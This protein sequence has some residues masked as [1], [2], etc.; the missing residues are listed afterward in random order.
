MF[1]VVVE[2]V[3]MVITLRSEY[4]SVIKRMG[5]I[6]GLVRLLRDKLGRGEFAPKT[7]GATP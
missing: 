6:D 7:A 4:G 2:G 1:D 5:G 3:S